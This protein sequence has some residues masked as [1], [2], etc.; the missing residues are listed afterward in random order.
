MRANSAHILLQ[1]ESQLRCQMRA[2]GSDDLLEPHGE[3]VAGRRR[4]IARGCAGD[5]GGGGGRL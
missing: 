2:V 5:G 1:P 3:L 4:F